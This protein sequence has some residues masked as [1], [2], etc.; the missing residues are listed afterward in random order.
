[1]VFARDTPN[2]PRNLVR[3]AS[4]ETTPIALRQLKSPIK[5]TLIGSEVK[6]GGGQAAIAGS[7]GNALKLH[8]A[9]ADFV[10]TEG[11]KP[12]WSHRVCRIQP[13]MGRDVLS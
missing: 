10:Y 1:M 9:A 3:Q 4:P 5:L 11:F 6:Q 8:F 7:S 2:T 13:Q 12:F